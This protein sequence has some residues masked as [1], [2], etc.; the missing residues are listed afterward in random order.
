MEVTFAQSFP[1]LLRFV[2]REPTRIDE[3]VRLSA[4]CRALECLGD[5]SWD[6]LET[7]RLFYG[8]ATKKA[9]LSGPAVSDGGQRRA[10]R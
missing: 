4:V 5:G 9:T 2:C 6:V 10:G 8:P 3:G 1:D 7:A